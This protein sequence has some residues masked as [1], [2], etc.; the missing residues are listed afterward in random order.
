MISVAEVVALLR[1]VPSPNPYPGVILDDDRDLSCALT[2]ALQ[3][4]DADDDRQAVTVHLAG[5]EPGLLHRRDAY[6][7]PP[8]RLN[9]RD[10][11]ASDQA[12]L[13]GDVRYQ[14][15]T[16]HCPVTNCSCSLALI[17]YPFRPPRCPVHPEQ[18]LVVAG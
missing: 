13:P 4:F 11:G 7:L 10:Y 1:P 3:Y 6:S 17:L 14:M 9:A 16:M 15:I 2:A 8:P 18:M 5:E 12:A